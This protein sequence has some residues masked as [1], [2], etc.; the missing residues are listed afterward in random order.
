[1]QQTDSRTWYVYLQCTFVG[2]SEN[3]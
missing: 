1:L 3:I 2:A